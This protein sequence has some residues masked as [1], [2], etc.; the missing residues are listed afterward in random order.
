MGRTKHTPV[1]SSHAKAVTSPAKGGPRAAI[2]IGGARK[3]LP[4]G[5]GKRKSSPATGGVK[6]P[7]RYR[8]GTLALR[9]IKHYQKSTELLLRKLP[10][11]RLVQEVALGRR[12]DLRFQKNALLALQEAS[13]AYLVGVFEDGNLEAIH[14]KRVTIQAKDIVLARRIRGETPK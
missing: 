10:F 13:E 9:A 5:K 1:R 12:S 6:K 14:G 4:T 8:P 3:V 11:A 2:P 7:Y